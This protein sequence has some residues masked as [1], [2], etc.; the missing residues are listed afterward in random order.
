M[1]LRVVEALQ[2]SPDCCSFWFEEVLS[3][4]G[5]HILK[6]LVL[7]D[8]IR[9]NGIRYGVTAY[10]LQQVADLLECLMPTPKILDLRAIQANHVEPVFNSGSPDYRIAAVMTDQEYS[11]RVDRAHE[12]SLHE[13]LLDSVGKSWVLTKRLG[14]GQYD[15]RTAYNYGWH[16][17]CTGWTHPSASGVGLSVAQPLAGAHNAYDQGGEG[18]PDPGGHRDPSQGTFGLVAREAMLYDE[19]ASECRL[20]D[21]EEVLRDKSLAHLVSHEGPLDRTRQLGVPPLDP[22]DPWQQD[23]RR[24]RLDRFERQE[25]QEGT[26]DGKEGIS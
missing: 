10:E 13:G 21:L 5:P 20:V 14:E 25:P 3:K 18:K 4:S 22:M 7:G 11:E 17:Y 26:S 24:E 23:Y 1:G 15:A 8:S 12:G 2:T 19:T 16:T 6:L 9:V